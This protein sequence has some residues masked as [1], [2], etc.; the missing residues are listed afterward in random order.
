MIEN[1]ILTVKEHRALIAELEALRIAKKPDEVTMNIS[2]Q[3]II[4][5]GTEES[6]LYKIYPT[7]IGFTGKVDFTRDTQKQMTDLYNQI[8]K[9]VIFTMGIRLAK[10]NEEIFNY[11]KELKSI[12]NKWWYKLFNKN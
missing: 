4:N 3:I 9:E 7:Y 12:K 10:A 6:P 8:E 2:H 5:I 1:V 11:K